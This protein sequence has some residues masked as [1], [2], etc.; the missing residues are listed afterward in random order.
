MFPWRNKKKCLPFTPSYL[1][2]CYFTAAGVTCHVAAVTSLQVLQHNTDYILFPLG[3]VSP[4]W[5]LENQIPLKLSLGAEYSH[6]NYTIVHEETENR[7][8]DFLSFCVFFVSKGNL[9]HSYNMAICN[10][11]CFIRVY[12]L[13]WFHLEILLKT[14]LWFEPHQI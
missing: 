4:F 9:L 2:L 13:G 7:V 5:L 6:T 10:T 14:A 11:Y 3:T 1:E 8:Y 12:K